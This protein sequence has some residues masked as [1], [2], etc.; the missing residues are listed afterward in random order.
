M[1]III[2]KLLIILSIININQLVAKKP[3]L[4]LLK[5]YKNQNIEN[6]V[7]SE[8]FDAFFRPRIKDL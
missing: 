7:M 1:N 6:W 8:K 5:I 3:N 4:L 2:L